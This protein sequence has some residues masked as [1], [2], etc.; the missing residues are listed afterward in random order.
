[1]KTFPVV[2]LATFALLAGC[3]GPP[4]SPSTGE[5]TF[6]AKSTTIKINALQ[7]D[8]CYTDPAREGAPACEKYVTQVRNLANTVASGAKT[9]YPQLGGPSRTLLENVT[10][11]R[12][13]GCNEQKSATNQVCINALTDIAD[14]LDKTV[15]T[16]GKS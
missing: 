3:G 10:T 11:Y 9:K 14:A 13:N 5:D 8:P 6:D 1:M 12:K 4:Q 2:T 16:L 7:A 15:E